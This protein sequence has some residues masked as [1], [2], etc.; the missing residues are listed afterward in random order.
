MTQPLVAVRVYIIQM[1]RNSVRE[2]ASSLL[3]RLDKDC[4]ISY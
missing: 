4:H 2:A 1:L 3:I